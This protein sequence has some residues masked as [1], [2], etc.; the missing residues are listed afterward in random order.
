M[1]THL[2]CFVFLIHLNNQV[3]SIFHVEMNIKYISNF[4]SSL[5]PL[6]LERWQ[7]IK[8]TVYFCFPEKHGKIETKGWNEG[9]NSKFWRT[10][11]IIFPK[12]YHVYKKHTQL[13]SL[14]WNEFSSMWKCI[15]F[16]KHRPMLFP[17]ERGAMLRASFSH[18]AG[19]HI[20]NSSYWKQFTVNLYS[21]SLC[22]FCSNSYFTK[23]QEGKKIYPVCWLPT[24]C[25]IMSANILYSKIYF[26]LIKAWQWQQR[27]L[28]GLSHTLMFLSK[29]FFLKD[30]TIKFLIQ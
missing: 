23:C 17:S 15:L 1:Y 29:C 27:K 16:P 20:Q 22:Q 2:Y 5:S 13:C 14:P 28:S 25:M 6:S 11:Q 7:S 8:E 3:C 21:S 30:K 18:A 24:T 9:T 4:K 12:A 19:V 10:I 26:A